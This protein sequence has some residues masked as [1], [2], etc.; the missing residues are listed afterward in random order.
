MMES[1]DPRRQW[2]HAI[3]S[4]ADLSS[5]LTEAQWQTPSPCPGWS[6]GDLVAHTVDIE[7]RMAGVSLP[8]YEPDWASLPHVTETGR[9]MEPG[10]D[11]RRGLDRSTVLDQLA[12]IILTRSAQMADLDLDA[13]IMSPRGREISMLSMM[14]MRVFDIWVHE[15]DMRTAIHQPG[16]LTS[17]SA[18]LTQSMIVD[19]LPKLWAKS[20]AAPSG[21]VLHIDIT[22][23]DLPTSVLVRAGDDGRGEQLEAY[24]GQ[25]DVTVSGT[26]PQFLAATTGRGSASALQLSGNLSLGAA[27]AS[28]LNITP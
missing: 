25:A 12:A 22:G 8:D 2:L 16:N 21:A 10:V 13:T 14:H 23:D 24:D 27:L 17:E 6:V 4:F 15:Q 1:T 7:E 9:S 19:S 20:A 18:R 28:H 5:T 26:W 3:E 11:R